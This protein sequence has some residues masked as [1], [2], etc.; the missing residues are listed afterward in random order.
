M[1]GHTNDPLIFSPIE[2]AGPRGYVRP[3]LCFSLGP[4]YDQ[5]EVV[6]I[7]KGGLEATKQTVP[8]LAAE[9]VPDTET[10][11]SGCVTLQEGDFPELRVKRL[12]E[13][14]FPL[15]YDQFRAKNFPTE[16]LREDTLCATP[17][18]PDPDSQLP[19]FV[20]Q[21]N[22]VDGGL[23]LSFSIFQLVVDGFSITRILH[24]WAQNCRKQQ[25][26]DTQDSIFL[27][28]SAFERAPLIIGHLSDPDKA[29][30]KDFPYMVHADEPLPS[31]FPSGHR[32]F[33]THLYHFTPDALARLRH[34][35]SQPGGPK[36]SQEEALWALMWR[37]TVAAQ[38]SSSPSDSDS[39]DT[40][41]DSILTIAIP[42]R[43][44][45]FPP[46]AP[47]YM[48]CPLVYTHPVAPLTASLLTPSPDLADLAAR[49]HAAVAAITP[50]Y[51]SSLVNLFAKLDDYACMAP[52]SFL[53][54]GGRHAL[55][56]SWAELPFYAAE[57]GAA[58]G[59]RC[60]RARTVAE[61]IL[62]GCQL[63]MPAVPAEAGGGVEVAMG[64]P[65][66]RLAA[67]E[68][69]EV[70]GRYAVRA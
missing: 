14:E 59:G 10:E 7:L 57:W 28:S 66:E 68:G 36:I 54:L 60:E 5:D 12:S 8:Y 70:W 43:S 41:T 35:A 15:S 56:A 69:D 1:F 31:T 24:I 13:A 9:I 67:L 6:R 21:A 18:F 16:L 42:S 17:V 11:R 45:T 37:C 27:S 25:D 63:V 20:A 58:L 30:P 19:V 29:D 39:S 62:N 38:L 65:E 64:L 47:D 3:I 50:H 53:E 33:R 48:G 23:L 34:D 46:L 26:P 22:F 51:V 44:R 52:A 40:T 2:Q 49:V 32:N 61:G 55:T 4:S